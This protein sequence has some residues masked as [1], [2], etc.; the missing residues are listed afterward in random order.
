M[1]TKQLNSKAVKLFNKWQRDFC[2]S[3][4][5]ATDEYFNKLKS[6]K[7]ECLDLHNVVGCYEYLT[8][9]NAL[10]MAS[11]CSSLRF[12]EPYRMLMQ[13]QKQTKTY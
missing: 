11:I 6:F 9:K 8:N 12:V 2:D 4:T 1:T 3:S 13:L 7:K 5:A 10:K